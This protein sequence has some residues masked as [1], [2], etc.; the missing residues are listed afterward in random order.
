MDDCCRLCLATHGTH[1]PIFSIKSNCLLVDMIKTICPI[2]IESSDPLPKS[3][4]Q[5]IRLRFDKIWFRL[6]LTA[7]FSECTEIVTTA[8]HLRI[9]SVQNDIKLRQKLNCDPLIKSEVSLQVIKEMTYSDTAY[10]NHESDYIE[11]DNFEPISS[12]SQ[13]VWKEEHEETSVVSPKNR[14]TCET[15]GMVWIP[16]IKGTKNWLKFIVL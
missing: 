5:G 10:E 4:C 8:Y 16:F 3:I 11:D 13:S 1:E 7:L 14:Y 12:E 15:C 6:N 2:S 9:L